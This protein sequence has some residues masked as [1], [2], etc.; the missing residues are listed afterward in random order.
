MDLAVDND[1]SGESITGLNPDA[2]YIV[3]ASLLSPK[4]RLVGRL[5]RPWRGSHTIGELCSMLVA[6]SQERSDLDRCRIDLRWRRSP[7]TGA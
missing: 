5:E 1:A 4:G 6:N 7:S 3:T 2:T